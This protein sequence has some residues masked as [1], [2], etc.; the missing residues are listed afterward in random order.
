[1]KG[2]EEILNALIQK[3]LRPKALRS[4][5]VGLEILNALI[6]KGLRRCRSVVSQP[7]VKY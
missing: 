5:S 7:F 4:V 1:M 6:Q 3:G 2:R